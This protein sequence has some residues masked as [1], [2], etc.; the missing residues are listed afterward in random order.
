MLAP[1]ALLARHPISLM[2]VLAAVAVTAGVLV[3][4]RPEY[5]RHTGTTIT[6]PAKHPADDAGGAAGWVWRDGR[7]GWE[8]G[9]LVKGFNASGVQP[10]ELQAAQLAAARSGLDAS[11]VRVLSSIRGGRNGVLAIVAAP[12]VGQTPVTTCLAAVLEGDA[13]VDWQC[14]GATPLPGDLEHSRVLIAATRYTW[15]SHGGAEH[16][17]Y[18]VGVARGDV[19]RVVLDQAGAEPMTLYTRGTTWGQFAAAVADGDGAAKLEIYGRRGLA[20]TLLLDVAPGRQRIF[21]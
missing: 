11:D 4:A 5:S 1:M 19:H 2:V 17:L 21:R 15:R 7:P 20:Q 9:A 16:P 14:P 10:V 3:F 6:L 13:P 18:L 12:T 8:P